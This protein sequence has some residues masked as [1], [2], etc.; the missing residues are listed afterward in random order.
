MAA[1]DSKNS[2]SVQAAPLHGVIELIIA[3]LSTAHAAGPKI[4]AA[5]APKMAPKV[6]GPT[7]GTAPTRAAPQMGAA[8][9]APKIPSPMGTMT[10]GPIYRGEKE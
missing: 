9:A 8:A 10:N 2:G 3:G 4:I 6:E 5:V 7:A 1:K